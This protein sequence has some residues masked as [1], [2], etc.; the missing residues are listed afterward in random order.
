MGDQ[1]NISEGDLVSKAACA[2]SG[3]YDGLDRSE[4][5]RD[6]RACPFSFCVFLSFS[7]AFSHGSDALQHAEVLHGLRIAA[8][9]GA[10]L[11]VRWVEGREGKGTGRANAT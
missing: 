7:I 6:P 3:S 5:S 11:A 10:N 9:D 8:N 4:A 2:C 1:A